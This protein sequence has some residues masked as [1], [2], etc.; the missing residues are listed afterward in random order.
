MLTILPNDNPHGTV[1]F[2]QDDFIVL[3]TGE[4][5]QYATVNRRYVQEYTYINH[6]Y[7]LGFLEFA[8]MNVT[9]DLRWAPGIVYVSNFPLSS[10]YPFKIQT[11][12]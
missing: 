9:R 7:I 5:E 4:S 10:S 6:D 1:T 3:E 11:H 2:A 8:A 12:S